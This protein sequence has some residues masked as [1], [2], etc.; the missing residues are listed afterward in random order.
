MS[1]QMDSWVLDRNTGVSSA[2]PDPSNTLQDE[3]VYCR[4]S[5]ST[6]AED[7]ENPYLPVSL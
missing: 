7:A 1:C 3:T 2:L 4:D 6:F 5:C